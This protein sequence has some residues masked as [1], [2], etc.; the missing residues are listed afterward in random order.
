MPPVT[1]STPDALWA[2]QTLRHL[3][4][5][6]IQCRGL[7]RRIAGA[8]VLDGLDLV[9]PVG[10]R[11]LV[12]SRPPDAAS[13]LLRIL[14]GVARPDGGTLRLAGLELG[15]DLPGGWARRVAYLPPTDALP[16]WMSAREAI[17]LS[18]RLLDYDRAERATRV[19]RAMARARI[20]AA[21]EL[22]RPL[23]RASQIERQLVALAAALVGDPEI[24]L[25]DEPLRALEPWE[26]S[27]ILGAL[28][29]RATLVVASRSPVVD[30][31][32]AREVAFIDHGRLA[33]HAPIT[34]LTRRGLPLTV[35]GLERLAAGPHGGA[36]LA[37]TRP[38]AATEAR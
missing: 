16:V 3:Q 9:V 36:A 38:A 5:A 26:R 6:A 13:L 28:S 17:D 37:A 1:I 18:A 24:L 4:P 35:A 29:E 22:D 31:G 19:E 7:R 10:A 33:V 27:R 2:S 34:E 23:R 21:L 20:P 15:D 32:V 30:E 12:A 25:L 8:P 11:L 14:A